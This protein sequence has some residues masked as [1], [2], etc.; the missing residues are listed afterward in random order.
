MRFGG[1]APGTTPIGFGGADSSLWRRPTRGSDW[2]G[3]N[4]KW[5]SIGGVF[6]V[7]APVSALVRMPNHLDLFIVGH[8]G[9]VYTS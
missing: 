3:I 7:G 5:R 4:D 8:D 1:A 2:S 6:P 9:R